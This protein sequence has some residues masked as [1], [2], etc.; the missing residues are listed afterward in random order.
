MRNTKHGSFKIYDFRQEYKDSRD[1]ISHIIVTDLSVEEVIS[2]LAEAG[3]DIN[4]LKPFIMLP[5]DY[6]DIFD[7]SFR[8]NKKYEMRER[9]HHDMFGYEDGIFEKHHKE[10]AHEFD[11]IEKIFRYGKRRKEEELKL[12]EKAIEQL[13][14]VQQRRIKQHY[15]DQLNLS[16]IAERETRSGKAIRDSIRLALKK[17]QKFF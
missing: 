17:I 12:L 6:Q 9:F 2:K 14:E 5:L 13:T 16:Q 4:D 8:N 1:E 3:I 11:Y 7:E 10:H 15:Y